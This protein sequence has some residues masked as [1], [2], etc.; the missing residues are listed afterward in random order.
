M[1]FFGKA[2]SFP[3]MATRR[4]WY[5]LSILLVAASLVLFFTR[6]L[7]LTIDFTG[8][9]VVEATF[10]QAPSDVTR[11]ARRWKRPGF[12]DPTVQDFGTAHDISARLAP[13][14]KQTVDQVRTRV[15]TAL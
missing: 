12:K 3:F 4:I 9:T 5:T 13:D 15:T 8:G 2:T 7:N 6:G 14:P 1:E 10:P 11:C